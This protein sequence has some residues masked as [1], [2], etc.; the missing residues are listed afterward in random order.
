MVAALAIAQPAA[1]LP[2]SPWTIGDGWATHAWVELLSW[3]GW[4]VPPSAPSLDHVQA[5]DGGHSDPNGSPTTTLPGSWT[6]D[7]GGHSDPNG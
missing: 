6:S 5:A 4:V 1:A 7:D 3:L 2:M